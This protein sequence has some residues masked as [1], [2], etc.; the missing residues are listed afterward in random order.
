MNTTWDLGEVPAKTMPHRRAGR[1]N[2]FRIAAHDLG[3]N[4]VSIS[5]TVKD[6]WVLTGRC[7]ACS[8]WLT[9]QA[10]AGRLSEGRCSG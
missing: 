6:T 8:H 7:T 9:Y 4:M 5:S 2:D 1:A 10:R 3:H